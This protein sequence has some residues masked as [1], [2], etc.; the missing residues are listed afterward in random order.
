MPHMPRIGTSVALVVSCAAVGLL[1]VSS[2]PGRSFSAPANTKRPFVAAQFLIRPGSTLHGD[3]GTWSGTAPINYAY[4]WQRCND[5]GEACVNISGA[6]DTSYLVQSGDV[7]RTLRFKVT[8]SNS[9]GSSS[10]A[11]EPT[12][13]VSGSKNEPSESAPPTI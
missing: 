11:S 10:E 2:A 5:N 7:N 8:A 13:E 9:D 12:G 1:V 4:Q 3:R 6:R